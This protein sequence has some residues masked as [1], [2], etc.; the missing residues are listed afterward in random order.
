ME[1]FCNIPNA[2]RTIRFFCP[3]YFCLP[4]PHFHFCAFCAL[5]RLIIFSA[6][7][8]VSVVHSSV[9]SIL[10]NSVLFTFAT[11]QATLNKLT[12]AQ[13]GFGL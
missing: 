8:P 1:S 6:A 9:F 4:S 7:R 2:A 11:M 13:Q 3:S 5:P 10:T 12:T